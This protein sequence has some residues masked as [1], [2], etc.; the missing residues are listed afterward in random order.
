MNKEILIHKI[1]KNEF[2][3]RL[4]EHVIYFIQLMGTCAYTCLPKWELLSAEIWDVSTVH[5]NGT[6][7]P[8]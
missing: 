3:Y 5:E 8:K 4:R 2:V 1:R 7:H 6:L